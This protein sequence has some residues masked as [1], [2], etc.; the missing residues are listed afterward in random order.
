M[1]RHCKTQIIRYSV[2]G[3]HGGFS[4]HRPGFESQY[5]NSGS[6]GRQECGTLK[7]LSEGVKDTLEWHEHLKR[8]TPVAQLDSALDF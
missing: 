4:L 7:K 5:R 2:G 6:A 3:H 1:A 8:M